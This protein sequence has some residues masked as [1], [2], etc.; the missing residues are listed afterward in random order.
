MHHYP[1][2]SSASP[3]K[4][5]SSALP[6]E[7]YPRLDF[8]RDYRD[9]ELRVKSS[10]RSSTCAWNDAGT[11]RPAHFRGRHGL[12]VTTKVG[13][14]VGDQE[15]RW[16]LSSR[17]W[18][19]TCEGDSQTRTAGT[20]DVESSGRVPVPGVPAVAQWWSRPTRR[21]DVGSTPARRTGDP[22]VAWSAKVRPEDRSAFS[23]ARCRTEKKQ[24]PFWP[25]EC[26]GSLA[27][28]GARL[29]A[30]GDDASPSASMRMAAHGLLALP[31][32][33]VVSCEMVFESLS[34]VTR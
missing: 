28:N 24:D 23:E 16:W 12:D 1:T 9:L 14:I 22:T 19:G 32:V 30:Q 3:L 6:A 20:G 15:R 8:L 27:E 7:L 33:V 18:S 4:C 17:T 34:E 26:S 10:A 2:G 25:L 11:V 21:E 31:S 5:H 29:L 13:G